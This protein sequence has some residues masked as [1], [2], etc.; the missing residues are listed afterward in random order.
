MKT[1]GPN[2]TLNNF[3]TFSLFL[4]F[5]TDVLLA[6]TVSGTVI[7]TA[8]SPIGNIRV[9]FRRGEKGTGTGGMNIDWY[10][11]EKIRVGN[12]GFFSF[13][14]PDPDVSQNENDI[15]MLFTLSG[16]DSASMI[17]N[18]ASSGNF[19]ISGDTVINLVLTPI[20]MG[21]IAVRLIN[22]VD[23]TPVE[24]A[25][26]GA[27]LMV[28]AGDV[29]GGVTDNN[30]WVAFPGA[31]AG[32]Y[33][34]TANKLG[35]AVVSGG[36]ELENKEKDMLILE[37]YTSANPSTGNV[38]GSMLNTKGEPI[39]GGIVC[40]KFGEKVDRTILIGITDK[41]GLFIIT[42][43]PDEFIGIEGRIEAGADGYQ[44]YETSWVV[45]NT[46]LI[47]NCVLKPV[48]NN[49][50]F[51]EHVPSQKK[52]NVMIYIRKNELIITGVFV[53]KNLLVSVFTLQGKKLLHHNVINNAMSH[54][55]SLPVS[56][57]KQK[58]IIN[59]YDKGKHIAGNT[60]NYG[61]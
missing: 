38:E 46:T 39:E 37:T 33:R 4:L 35:W 27:E 36:L 45:D 32:T 22:Q 6:T 23:N 15:F 2:H 19:L 44:D 41:D 10:Y 53:R 24:G 43:V 34:I 29:Y 50:T 31:I 54:R 13:K 11:E 26:V 9:K 25:V 55:I 18:T 3:I 51:I 59:L 60:C 58:L 1:C 48:G 12:D 57:S 17:Y 52:S 42:N 7:D 20:S 5:I 56:I 21:D 61:L 16:V 40:L 49:G 14:V 28:N 8:G 47:I 30:G